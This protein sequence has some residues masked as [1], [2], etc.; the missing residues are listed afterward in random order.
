MRPGQPFD[1]ISRRV[2]QALYF[3]AGKV[4]DEIP[5]GPESRRQGKAQYQR[6]SGAYGAQVRQLAQDR[7][8]LTP[9]ELAAAVIAPAEFPDDLEVAEIALG[10]ISGVRDRVRRSR[11]G[12]GVDLDVPIPSD[13]SER[14]EELR[15]RARE[16]MAAQEARQRPEPTPFVR[17]YSVVPRF[18]YE[19]LRRPGRPLD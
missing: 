4:L 19:A 8:E 16:G 15:E 7:P 5:Y 9:D 13:L 10:I 14:V 11:Y 18:V 12:N 1:P 2:R 3:A 6:L 17:E